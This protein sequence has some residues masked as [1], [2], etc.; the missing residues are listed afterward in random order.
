MADRL[1]K[2]GKRTVLEDLRGVRWH[3]ALA[4]VAGG[5]LTALA[6]A[7]VLDS[8]GGSAAP[9][10]V[11]VSS[12][13]AP[14]GATREAP[15]ALKREAESPAGATVSISRMVGQRFM[16]GLREPMPSPA[17]LA[18]ARR[19]ELGGI[20][21]FT[22]EFGP[23]HVK[24]AIN[25]LQGAA[26]AGSNPPLLIA[27]DQEGGEVK[28]LPGPPDQPLSTLSPA[29]ALREGSATGRYLRSYGVNVDLAPVVDLGLSTSFMKSRTISAK[30]AKVAAVATEFAGG[31]E[32]TGV[33]PVAKHFPGLGSATHN[34][35]EERSVVEAEVNQS[36]IPYRDLIARVHPTGVMV[37][38]AIYTKLDPD[39]GA[40]WSRKIVSGV[41]RHRLGF[42]EG[43]VFSDALSS[44]GVAQ[45]LPVTEA[46]T[47]AAAAGVD[48]ILVEAE[49]FHPARDA[50]VRVAKEGQIPKQNLTS[51]YARILQAKEKFARWP[52]LG[53]ADW[54]RTIRR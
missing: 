35:D 22:E 32:Q 18:D 5:A 27:I 43:L 50:V 30:P 19:G 29:A 16:V 39:N 3:V 7:L 14:A 34:T 6:L 40:A 51:S 37:S 53:C 10:R 41:L 25:A 44:D 45:T 15:S 47:K 11:T 36:L 49:S 4:L 20:V 13:A 38:T 23:T 48:L 46:V 42:E 17:L 28:R 21:V 26:K 2:T 24:S 54:R 1:G 33:L 9:P 12:R 52:A 31:L 8:G